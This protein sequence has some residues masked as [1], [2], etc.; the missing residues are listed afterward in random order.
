LQLA[1]GEP[2]DFTLC[3]LG[4]SF[5]MSVYKVSIFSLVAVSFDRYLAICHPMVYKTKS[6]RFI[7]TVIAVC[8]L[9][10]I[11]LGF[12][13]SLGWNRGELDGL[14]YLATIADF[15][16]SF[17]ITA[18]I[19]LLAALTLAVFYF[20]IYREIVRMVM[21]FCGFKPFNHSN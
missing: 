14:C 21:T 19:D 11:F 20:L 10:G 8:W 1:T 12:L 17:Y 3:V 9:L 16:Y 5:M 7:K 6:S 15:Y 13:P 2:R 18:C 4:Y